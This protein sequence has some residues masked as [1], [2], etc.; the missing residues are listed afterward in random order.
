MVWR[1][2]LGHISENEADIIS[3]LLL[4]LRTLYPLK[5]AELAGSVGEQPPIIHEF[6]D[7]LGPLRHEAQ[8]QE[9]PFQS[10]VPVVGRFITG[11]REQ[12]NRVATKWYMRPILA[13]QN[14]FNQSII[15]KLAE[16]TN[17][18][19]WQTQR[20]VE[21]ERRLAEVLSEYV[22]ENSREIAALGAE[23]RELKAR[24]NQKEDGA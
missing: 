12:W 24:L 5:P 14:H 6:I 22:R 20:S 7:S 13:Q 8:I 21:R 15:S 16:T 18:H 1:Q 2:K 10:Q 4:Q 9:E 17:L 19:N 23:I 3:T 11:L